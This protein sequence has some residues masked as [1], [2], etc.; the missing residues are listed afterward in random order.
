M[1][2]KVMI[3]T[4]KCKEVCNCWGLPIT[5][6]TF[7]KYAS[8]R[9]KSSRPGISQN[10]RDTN[11]GAGMLIFLVTFSTNT[12]SMTDSIL[13]LYEECHENPSIY[14]KYHE[15]GATHKEVQYELRKMSK[16]ALF[17]Y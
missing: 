16:I 6:S 14:S 17:G 4:V 8:W 15:G 11:V 13:R 9:S 2:I 3:I 7:R 5:A 10:V 12:I 1:Q